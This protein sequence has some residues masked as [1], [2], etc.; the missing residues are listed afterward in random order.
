MP[1]S[2]RSPPGPELDPEIPYD[3]AEDEVDG[4]LPAAVDLGAAG[5]IGFQE[6]GGVFQAGGDGDGP[7]AGELVLF[8]GDGGDGDD[9]A[10]EAGLGVGAG[11]E[12]DALA[13]VDFGDFLFRHGDLGGD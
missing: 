8:G 3:A 13:G 9:G 12:N 10:F 1:A 11:L 5:H 2:L 6:H 7:L 4:A